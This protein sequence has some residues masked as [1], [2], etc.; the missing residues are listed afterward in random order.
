MAAALDSKELHR[1]A[2]L[3]AAE[4]LAQLERERAGL[5]RAFPELKRSSGRDVSDGLSP[6]GKESRR[7]RRPMSAQARK[8]VS[9]RM[10]KYWAERRAKRKTAAARG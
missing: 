9:L 3:G 10:K 7:R 1:L 2:R 5:L 4:R 8:A 6:T